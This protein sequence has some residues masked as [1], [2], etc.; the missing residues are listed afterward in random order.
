VSA[1][2]TWIEEVEGVDGDRASQIDVKFGRENVSPTACGHRDVECAAGSHGC[3]S[4][5]QTQT[6]VAT[7]SFGPA[8]SEPHPAMGNRSVWNEA[9]WRNGMIAG[10]SRSW[11]ESGRVRG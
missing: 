6:R 10:E 8:M 5:S 11:N 9:Q 7:G 2:S 3:R 1:A 4:F